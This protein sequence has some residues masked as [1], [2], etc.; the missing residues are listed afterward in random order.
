MIGRWGAEG[1]REAGAG[2]DV[3]LAAARGPVGAAKRVPQCW[4]NAKPTGVGL[5]QEGQSRLGAL[6][7]APVGA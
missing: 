6:T 5:P 3:G 4:Q 2:A 1:A 7:T